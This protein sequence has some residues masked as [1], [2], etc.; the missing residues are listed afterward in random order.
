MFRVSW[1]SDEGLTKAKDYFSFG[2]V[3]WVIRD[4]TVTTVVRVAMV[5][6]IFF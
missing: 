1:T 5:S 4:G 6:T 2:L 3:T